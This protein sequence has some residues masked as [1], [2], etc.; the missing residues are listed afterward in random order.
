MLCQV[1][2]RFLD[3]Y[4]SL[5]GQESLD[6]WSGALSSHITLCQGLIKLCPLGGLIQLYPLDGWGCFF[7]RV[8]CIGWKAR[9]VMSLRQVGELFQSRLLNGWEGSFSCVFFVSRRGCFVMSLVQ[10][11]RLVQ[12]CPLNE[13]KGSPIHVLQIGGEER[14][15]VPTGELEGSFHI[16][17]YI[18]DIFQ[19]SLQFDNDSGNVIVALVLFAE[20]K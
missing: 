11:G 13:W 18:A 14:L 16:I 19:Q 15:V 8:P 20:Q 12:S 10:V 17:Y 6:K 1:G 7:C 3:K 2:G 5:S 4:R 9:L